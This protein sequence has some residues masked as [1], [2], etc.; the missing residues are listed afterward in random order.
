MCHTG[1]VKLFVLFYFVEHLSTGAEGR[2]GYLFI[3]LIL[4]L[5]RLPVLFHIS[6]D[7]MN[8][9]VFI[10]IRVRPIMFTAYYFITKYINP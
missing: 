6:I 3:L 9:F 10:I 7:I 5:F 4:K 1:T 2:E 8:N